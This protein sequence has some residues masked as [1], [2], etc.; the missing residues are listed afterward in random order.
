MLANPRLEFLKL[1][2]NEKR[3]RCT[4][5][6]KCSTCIFAYSWVHILQ[7]KYLS[8]CIFLLPWST[9]IF[10]LISIL[11]CPILP[12]SFVSYSIYSFTHPFFFSSKKSADCDSLNW[13]YDPGMGHRL[14]FKKHCSLM[15]YQEIRILDISDFN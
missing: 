12:H 11:F 7:R 10:I 3:K 2:E 14:E 9:V 4:F 13:F 15:C 6:H 5:H 8:N 1:F